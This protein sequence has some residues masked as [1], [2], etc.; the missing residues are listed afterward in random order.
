METKFEYRAYLKKELARLYFP[1][2]SDD[3][4]A[5]KKLRRWIHRNASLYRELYDGPEGRNDQAFSRRQVEVIVKYLEE[6]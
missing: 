6:P 1:D 3:E 4:C 5:L 2:V